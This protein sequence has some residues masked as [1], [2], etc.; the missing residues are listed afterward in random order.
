MYT[1]DDEEKNFAIC[2]CKEDV[3]YFKFVIEHLQTFTAYVK[4]APLGT[5]GR[6]FYINDRNELSPTL[7]DEDA[8]NLPCNS[9]DMNLCTEPNTVD[10]STFRS[11]ISVNKRIPGPTIIVNESA[12]VV[13][14]VINKL[15]T[16]WNAPTWKSVDGWS[17]IYHSMS[18]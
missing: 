5:R 12:T 16:A 18:Y 3:C 4:E 14:D 11:F 10:G 6:I 15:V 7:K 13:V 1:C 8:E 2:E 9:N 17:W